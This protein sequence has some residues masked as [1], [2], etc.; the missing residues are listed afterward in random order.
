MLSVSLFQ[1][2]LTMKEF[3]HQRVVPFKVTVVDRIKAA[4][5]A[6]SL[7]LV[8]VAAALV[9]SPLTAVGAEA[10]TYPLVRDV[11]T[12]EGL[13]L[14]YYDVV[15]GPANTARNVARDVS[16]HHPDA[17]LMVPERG[18]EGRPGLIR[19]SVLQFHE[20]SKPTYA[21]GFYEREIKRE[22]RRFGKMYHVFSYYDTQK[23]PGG[24]SI[25]R[26][27]NSIQLYFDGTRFWIISETW[28]SETAANPLPQM[29]ELVH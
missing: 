28:E 17:Q 24:P 18:P 26:G 15:S 16:L 13:M 9:S 25:G 22:V 3:P 7:P 4:W 21:A 19:K 12:I 20:W 27:I 2:T 10:A 6:L 8:L 5:A 11:S 1:E 23:T 14:A 29:V